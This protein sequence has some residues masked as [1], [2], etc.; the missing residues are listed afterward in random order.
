MI[1][2]KNRSRQCQFEYIFKSICCGGA[3]LRKL[4][5]KERGGVISIYILGK[6]ASEASSDYLRS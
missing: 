6:H 1:F 2:F 5:P 3:P 4:A